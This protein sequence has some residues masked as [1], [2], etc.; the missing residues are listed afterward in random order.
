[1]RVRSIAFKSILICTSVVT[2]SF[3]GQFQKNDSFV[4]NEIEVDANENTNTTRRLNKSAGDGD[5]STTSA[6]SDHHDPGS[7]YNIAT[8]NYV[9][10]CEEFE[11]FDSSSYDVRT[12][13]YSGKGSGSGIIRDPVYPVIRTS[14]AGIRT[15]GDD[16]G[17][18]VSNGDEFPYASTAL[19]IS[20]Y[21]DVLNPYTDETINVQLC[22]SGF[23]VADNMVVSIA[24]NIF[25]YPFKLNDTLRQK[26][27][28]YDDSSRFAD[29]IEIYFQA[30][31]DIIDDYTYEVVNYSYYTYADAVSIYRD[32]YNREDEDSN[33]CAIELHQS[34]KNKVECFNLMYDYYSYLDSI[35]TPGYREN[36]YN[37][38]TMHHS[39]GM[40]VCS[41]DG[42]Y[43]T[44]AFIY[45]IQCGGPLYVHVN[46]VNIY[47][48]GIQCKYTG[49]DS[50]NNHAIIINYFMYH[51]FRSFSEASS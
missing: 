37:Q 3:S 24:N 11:T 49:C 13:K 36:H 38:I 48:L 20:T 40:L 39:A 18:E 42:I 34:M 33:W 2:L 21:Y 44:N 51:F 26:Y 30:T 41:H 8:Y 22:N 25:T 47:A 7:A 1:M 14:G 4:E 17:Y 27:D 31:A 28:D 15:L 35:F 29:K 32:Y 23:L 12:P 50:T 45:N 5:A 9:K 10:G 6:S 19:I 43:C 46:T 16:G